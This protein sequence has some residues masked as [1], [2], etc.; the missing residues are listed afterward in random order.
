[1]NQPLFTNSKKLPGTDFKKEFR[2][3]LSGCDALTIATGY[4]GLSTL[5]EHEVALADLAKRGS[6]RLLLG[7]AFHGGC[8]EKQAVALK[9]FDG[10]LKSI[11]SSS[12]VYIS[13]VPYHG[14]VYHFSNSA[15]NYLYIGSSNFSEDGLS[16]RYECTALVEDVETQRLAQQ[17]ITH[18]FDE[19]VSRPLAEVDLRISTKSKPSISKD[20]KDY[21]V[22]PSYFPNLSKAVGSFDIKLRVDSQPFSSL[23]LALERGRKNSR[24]GL[25][26]PRPWYEVEITTLKSERMGNPLYPKRGKFEAYHKDGDKFYKIT[27]AVCSAGDK[28]IQSHESSGGRCT[29]GK[30]IKGKLERLGLLREGDRITSDLLLEYGRDDVTFVKIKEGVYVLEF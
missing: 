13:L 14:K 17:Y 16:S 10:L 11:N 3:H 29:L 24:T 15:K 30:L 22:A 26:S 25:Y 8:T 28:A 9:A 6:F 7:M 20:L 2:R 19:S 21:Q 5:K 4:L 1:M 12:G 18:L 23:N 27:M